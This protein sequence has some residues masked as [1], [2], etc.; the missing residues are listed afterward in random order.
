MADND[1]IVLQDL[2]ETVTLID[3][4]YREASPA[5]RF[6]MKENRDKALNEYGAA[7]DKLIADGV[8]CTDQQVI[9][10]R[11]LKAEVEHA[12]DTQMLIRAVAQVASFIVTL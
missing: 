9:E 1:T 11:K 6:E 3:V 12:A 7:R 8:I 5:A 10:M 2:G 4:K